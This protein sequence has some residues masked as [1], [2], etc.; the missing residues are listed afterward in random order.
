MRL[1]FFLLLPPSG[2]IIYDAQFLVIYT[3]SFVVP[4]GTAL[5]INGG[6]VSFA[7]G[8]NWGKRKEVTI[9]FVAFRWL[10]DI[11]WITGD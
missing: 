7:R 11:R 10:H 8:E 3:R 6:C 2:L 1:R 5:G 9:L 4:S